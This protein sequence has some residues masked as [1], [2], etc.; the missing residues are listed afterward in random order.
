MHGGIEMDSMLKCK[1]C[2]EAL[3][4]ELR[5]P[6]FICRKCGQ[7]HA[8]DTM[9]ATNPPYEEKVVAELRMSKWRQAIEVVRANSC[10]DLKQ[11]RD[12]VDGLAS[13]YKIILPK[14]GCLGV[15]VLFLA[16]MTVLVF[17]I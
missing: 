17:L 9:E 13:R 2:G 11:S 4:A 14:K 5:K 8:S 12:Y 7:Q 1:R 16:G 15:L 3:I 10:L 6:L